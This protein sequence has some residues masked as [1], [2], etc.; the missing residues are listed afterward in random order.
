MFNYIIKDKTTR[1]VVCLF[2]LIPLHQ[3][4]AQTSSPY[5]NLP[6]WEVGF[7][8]VPLLSDD[9]TAHWPGYFLVR[10]SLK[11]N[12]RLRAR[13][14]FAM[15]E[16]DNQPINPIGFGKISGGPLGFY[17]SLGIEKHFSLGRVGFY[18]GLEGYAQYYRFLNHQERDQ[19][20]TTN[21]P[22]P[23]LDITDTYT[24]RQYGLQLFPGIHVR[25]TKNLALS[26]E[27][28]LRFSYQHVSWIT[29]DYRG[30]PLVLS[31]YDETNNRTNILKLYTLGAFHVVYGF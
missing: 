27:S 3:I 28:H 29:E 17:G 21:P 7:D 8:A 12:W 4:G 1:W 19:S 15:Y 23:P 31:D 2:C 13:V 30:N 16:T 9:S 10:L 24:E 11:D 20:Q 5:D 26:F 25:I 22:V 18:L 6:K 14:G